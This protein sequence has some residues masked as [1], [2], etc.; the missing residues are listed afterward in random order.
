MASSVDLFDPKFRDRHLRAFAFLATRFAKGAQTTIDCLMPFVTYAVAHHSE[1]QF[2]PATIQTFLKDNYYITVPLYTLSD[3]ERELERLGFLK[4]NKLTGIKLC[5]AGPATLLPKAD[6]MGFGEKDFADLDLSLSKFAS[7]RGVSNPLASSS[8]SEALVAFFV[9]QNEELPRKP[10][11]VRDTLLA[12]GR[13]ID[14]TLLA[15]F[16][17][18][19]QQNDRI[20]YSVVERVFYGVCINDFLSEIAEKKQDIQFKNVQIIYDT[21]ILMRLLGTSGQLFRT[22]S[23]EL[24]ES[25]I[26]LGCR[27]YYFAHTFSE[28][29]SNL[30]AIIAGLDAASDIH[31]ETATAIAEGGTSR[32]KIAL[33]V[34]SLDTRLGQLGITQHSIGY[35]QRDKDKYQVDEETF[36][37]MLKQGRPGYTGSAVTHDVQATAIILRLRSGV[38]SYEFADC[39]AIFV[40][41]NVYFASRARQFV[42]ESQ[43]QSTRAVPPVITVGQAATIGWVAGSS[44]YQPEKIT[45]ELISN[46]VRATLPSA[47]WEAE[48]QNLLTK[49]KSE[50]AAAL[51][52]DALKKHALREIVKRE[53]FGNVSLVKGVTLDAALKKASEEAAKARDESYARGQS[54]AVGR[55]KT[56]RG[57]RQVEIAD[58]LGERLA[59]VFLWAVLILSGAGTVWFAF[60][61]IAG[62][63]DS[64]VYLV[65][66]LV[67]A[68][69]TLFDVLGKG[70]RI[71]VRRWSKLAFVKLIRFLQN[72]LDPQ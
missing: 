10:Q 51:N 28:L 45:K 27:T 18:H 57:Q 49:L 25:L 21:P 39:K 14:N 43:L 55:L 47:G 56:E 46:C 68:L 67:L 38:T 58:A 23:L 15:D 71:P 62:K 29:E 50:D 7:Q 22:A 5:A 48:F 9:S 40:T 35:S 6:E 54:D 42:R 26:S 44:V 64:V 70:P 19:A 32:E 8:W 31:F 59:T 2:V 33:L 11:K 30:Q 52:S 53:S 41:H 4:R 34:A 1:K 69:V 13:V 61:T 17:L 16:I 3:M 24:H 66:S 72:L 37:K 12:D 36:G 20:T 60:P 65:L 63:G